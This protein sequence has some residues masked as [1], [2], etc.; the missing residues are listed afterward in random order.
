[1][2]EAVIRTRVY[3]NRNGGGGGVRLPQDAGGN[4]HEVESR[5][6]AQHG[7]FEQW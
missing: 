2:N 1:M 6:L 3:E 4:D 7:A 5:G